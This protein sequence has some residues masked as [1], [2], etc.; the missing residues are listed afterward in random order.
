VEPDSG[1]GVAADDHAV[2][3]YNPGTGIVTRIDPAS[4]RTV[5]TIPVESE[6]RECG[7]GG[8]VAIGQG[9]VWV[10]NYIDGTIARIDPQMNKVVATIHTKGGRFTSPWVYA[11]PG[12]VWVADYRL[13]EVSRIDLQTNTLVPV[14]ALSDEPGSISMSYGAGS[15]WLC[16]YHGWPSLLRLDPVTLRP[17]AEI[18]VSPGEISGCTT[19]VALDQAV[20]VLA[21]GEEGAPLLIERVD[22]MTN[23]VSAAVTP[24]GQGDAVLTA[25]AHGVWYLEP[26]L[27][28][29]RLDPQSGKAVAQTPLH[30]GAGLA[31]GAGSVWVTSNNGTLMR[32]TPTL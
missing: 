25:D 28:L 7:Y 11:T 22:P 13:N 29:F 20:W 17:Q 14:P 8:D 30:D 26:N 9:S 4:N 18:D 32:I 5:V 12:A 6:C 1:Y 24:P 21:K 3:V 16:D 15:L 31:L 23:Q 2:W 27:G 10:S 19:V